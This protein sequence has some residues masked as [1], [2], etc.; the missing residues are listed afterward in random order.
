M[1]TT[2]VVP[3]LACLLALARPVLA[4]TPLACDPSASHETHRSL[5]GADHNYVTYVGLLDNSQKVMLTLAGSAAGPIRGIYFGAADL[6]DH[7]VALCLG[8]GRAVTFSVADENGSPRRVFVGEFVRVDPRGRFSG[9]LEREVMTGVVDD[10]TTGRRRSLVLTMSHAGFG[11]I[12]NLYVAAGVTNDRMVD[13]QAQ[14]FQKALRKHDANAVAR[15]IRFPIAVS[16]DGK[17]TRV[18][19]RAQFQRVYARVMTPSFTARVLAAIPH[20]MFS[21]DQGVMLG[22]GEV[23]FDARGQVIALNNGSFH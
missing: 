1:K 23:W 11:T 9:A 4:Q 22:G 2:V 18:T 10:R 3:L 6:I 19:S 21:R 15:M 13:V 5:W 16:V 7:K 17:R 20:H 8:D 12:E 14:A